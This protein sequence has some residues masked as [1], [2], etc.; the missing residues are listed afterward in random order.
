M[1][2]NTSVWSQEPGE[3]QMHMDHSMHMEPAEHMKHMK[4]LQSKGDFAVKDVNYVIPDETLLNTSGK[5]I[6]LKKILNSGKPVALNFI[7]TTC[8]TICPVMT[9]TFSQMRHQLGKASSK[10][11]FVSIT[12]DPEYD[13]PEVLKEYAAR[14]SAGEGW[15][16]LTGDGNTINK[17]LRSFDVDSGSKMN[18]QPITLF[19][20]PKSSTWIRVNGLASG[21]QMAELATERLLN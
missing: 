16:F 19:K 6:S 17:V 5:N 9:A 20:N 1:S 21:K 11:Q 8:T 15:S 14:F 2:V 3:H 13:R 12:I 4:M 7:F 18:H 10:I